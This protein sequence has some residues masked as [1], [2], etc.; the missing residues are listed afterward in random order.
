MLMSSMS[1]VH[2]NDIY[3]YIMHTGFMLHVFCFVFV[4]IILLLFITAIKVIQVIVTIM[5]TKMNIYIYIMPYIAKEPC[6]TSPQ[7]GNKWV[8]EILQGNPDRCKQNFRME[9]HVFI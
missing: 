1:P 4:F 2:R 3:C 7:T 6:R 9:I 8:I 5:K